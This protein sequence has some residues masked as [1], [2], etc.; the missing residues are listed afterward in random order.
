MADKQEQIGNALETI[1]YYRSTVEPL[2]LSELSAYQEAVLE[3]FDVVI[4][5]LEKML[6]TGKRDD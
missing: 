2:D 1:K 5:I 6:E 3:D 4:G